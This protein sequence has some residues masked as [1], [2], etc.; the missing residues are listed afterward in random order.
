MDRYIPCTNEY[1]EENEWLLIR[2]KMHPSFYVWENSTEKVSTKKCVSLALSDLWKFSPQQ[3]IMKVL[4]FL[5]DSRSR[6]FNHYKYYTMY[7][8]ITFT[9]SG[10][11][12]RGI[13][14][15]VCNHYCWLNCGWSGCSKSCK[16]ILCDVAC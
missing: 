5:F 2:Q 3:D 1:T 9:G 16:D 11:R 4:T 13:C 7:W 14:R 12:R 8:F 6:C 10:K 15:K